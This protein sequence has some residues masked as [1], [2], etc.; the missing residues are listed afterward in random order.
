[1]ID[2]LAAALDLS[3]PDR[4]T[5]RTWYERH[6]APYHVIEIV[7]RGAV[8]ETMQ[9]INVVN[10]Q[11]YCIRL[12]MQKCPFI[13]GQIV[14][15]SLVPWRGEW[16]WSGGQRMWHKADAAVLA[17]LKKEYVEKLSVISYRYCADLAQKA[18]DSVRE[19]HRRFVAHHNADLAVYSDGLSLAA[20]TQKRTAR[21]IRRATPGNRR[22][23][24]EAPRS[25]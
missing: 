14:I 9:V 1:M 12:E 24:H 18:R 17:A 11:P 7:K 21:I 22:G 15:G 23:C 5:L 10:D 3:E 8:A 13:A 16:Y 20:A 6:N 25:S 2:L 4:A 19:H